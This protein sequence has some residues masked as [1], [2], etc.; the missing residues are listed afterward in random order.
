MLA[1]KIPEDV[2]RRFEV[3]DIEDLLGYRTFHFPA[4]II[5]RYPIIR[6]RSRRAWPRLG[7]FERI[8]LRRKRRATVFFEREGFLLR[9]T[10]LAAPELWRPSKKEW[11]Y[12]PYLNGATSITKDEAA[13]MAESEEALSLPTI[14]QP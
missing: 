3:E 11:D 2:A 1:F 12:Y 13:E 8:R 4:E 7:L 6:V 5:N 14:G 10:G 9:Q